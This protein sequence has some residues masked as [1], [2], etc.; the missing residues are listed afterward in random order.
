MPVDLTDKQILIALANNP[1][2]SFRALA[3]HLELSVTAV[4]NRVV[5]L[6]DTGVIRRYFISPSF[7]MLNAEFFLAFLQIKHPPPSEAFRDHLGAYTMIDHV[8]LLADGNVLCWGKYVG[9]QGLDELTQFLYGLEPVSDVEL[10]TL[11]VERGKNCPLNSM[12]IQVLRCLRKDVR[13]PVSEI[14]QSTGLTQRRVRKLLVELIGPDGSADEYWFHEKGVGDYRTSQQCF[15]TRV[16]SDIAEGGATR[17]F[18]YITYNGGDEKRRHIAK[19][20]ANEYP[21]EY[22]LSVASAS[23]PVLF[24]MFLVE[25]ANRSP[26]IINRIKEL[27][28]VESV[29]PILYFSH[30]FYPGLFEQFWDRLLGTAETSNQFPKLRKNTS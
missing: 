15:H 12:H 9:S 16:D 11:L 29:R 13:M 30:H 26:Q 23:A 27:D 21:I 2:M 10:H 5:K 17:F 3:R 18:A 7:A 19:V 6:E 14:S 4:R 20:L 1:R 24:S 22:W 8:N 25:V 28:G